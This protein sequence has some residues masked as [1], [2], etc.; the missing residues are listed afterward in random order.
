MQKYF[1][2]KNNQPE[3]PFS[4]EELKAQKITS[5]TMVWFEGAEDWQKASEI[6]EL[7][8]LIKS[9]PPPLKNK[10]NA[11]PP[12]I[13]SNRITTTDDLKTP[14]KNSKTPLLFAGFVIILILVFWYIYS[15]QQESE[16]LIKSRLQ[17]QQE[18]LEQQE[19]QIQ[20]QQQIES[21]RIEEQNA[22]QNQKRI[23]ERRRIK[24]SL[25]YDYDQALLSLKSANL[26]LDEI[27]KFVMLRT[28]AE[29]EQQIEDQLQ[30][31]LSWEN[32]VARLKR[33]LRKY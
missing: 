10:S 21:S 9:I 17:D 20:E 33:E 22:V 19:N 31:I 2:H 29:K 28:K 12:K 23:N 27:Q 8:E 3:G 7:S 16:Y 18:V 15:S 24:E 14:K 5:D 1:V 11:K 30:V 4:I 13:E 32:E 26:K 6:I 25:Q